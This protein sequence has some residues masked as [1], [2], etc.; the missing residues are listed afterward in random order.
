MPAPYNIDIGLQKLISGACPAGV[1]CYKSQFVPSEDLKDTPKGYVF[2]DVS[3]IEPALCSEGFSE[4]NGRESISFNVDI[5]VVHHDNTQ[6]KS[7]ATSVLN[8]LQPT[9]SGRRTFL[10]SYQ[11]P[12]TSVFIQNLRMVS[13]DEQTLLKT[14]Q[15]TPDLTML[16]FNFV[17]K[18][19]C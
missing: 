15:G 3:E 2:F 11:V 4:A 8:V 1:P 6:R 10:T 18:A 17:G 13:T 19:T 9:V 5:A 12:Q 16:V 14:G 7:V